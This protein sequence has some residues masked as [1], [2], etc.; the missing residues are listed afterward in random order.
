MPL[1]WKPLG[2]NQVRQGHQAWHRQGVALVGRLA[3]A[4]FNRLDT[5]RGLGFSCAPRNRLEMQAESGAQ[6]LRSSVLEPEEM[7]EFTTLGW[8]F[9]QQTFIECLPH[10]RHSPR[11]CWLISGW[12]LYTSLKRSL[13]GS[14]VDNILLLKSYKFLDIF[15]RNLTIYQNFC[16]A[17]F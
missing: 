11:V 3:Q 8:L 9:I 4:A 12:G 1:S 16:K 5:S 15:Y 7:S 17:V 14:H 6:E 10:V 2:Q 13:C